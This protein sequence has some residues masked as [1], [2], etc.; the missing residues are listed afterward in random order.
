MKV[1][2]NNE[3]GQFK[4]V[5]LST[6]SDREPVKHL[7][8]PKYAEIVKSGKDP[9][10]HELIEEVENFRAVLE[11]FEV[12]V[13]RPKNVKNHGQIFCR[14][15]GFTIGNDFF[16]GKMKKENRQL[17]VDGI[18]EITS[19]FK[20]VHTPPKEA[21]IEGGDVM[22]WKNYVFVGLGDRTNK[23]GV[24]FLKSVLKDKKEVIA[25]PLKVT[26]EGKLHYY[27]K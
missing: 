6:A 24:N 1:N 11:R 7:N 22:V 5:I 8:N 21:F 27:T 12:E 20:H 10:E 23:E 3:T 9:K 13:L 4:T 19:H 15:I 25:L 2:V 14:D 17:E 18:S 26:D 16:Y